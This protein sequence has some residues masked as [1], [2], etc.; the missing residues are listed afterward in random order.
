MPD[1]RQ[2]VEQ[3][4]D[5]QKHYHNLHVV[6]QMLEVG[7]AI[8]VLDYSRQA[9]HPWLSGK[10]SE[11]TG[12]VSYRCDIAR[13]SQARRHV[14]QMRCRCDK[15]HRESTPTGQAVIESN[16]GLSSDAG[17]KASLAPRD[18][19]C[20]RPDKQLLDRDTEVPALQPDDSDEKVQLDTENLQVI[21]PPPGASES[22]VQTPVSLRRSTRVRSKPVRL[23]L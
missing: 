14:D 7:E 10:V 8:Y 21:T 13:S 15:S 18:L 12:P 2:R 11:R 19:V 3:Q 4:L 20:E 22:K 16:C 17:E 6:L 1:T 5:R 23:N 9:N